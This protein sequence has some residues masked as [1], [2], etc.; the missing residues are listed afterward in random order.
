MTLIARTRLAL[1]LV[2]TGLLVAYTALV[3]HDFYSYVDRSIF[4]SVDDS[5]AN[6]AYTVSTA[7][8]TIRSRSGSVSSTG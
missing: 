3:T 6:I 8:E 2:L 1:V 4:A 7:A 5:E